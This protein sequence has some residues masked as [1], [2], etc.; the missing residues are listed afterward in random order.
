LSSRGNYEPAGPDGEF[1]DTAPVF[2]VGDFGAFVSLFAP[3]ASDLVVGASDFVAEV[4]SDEDPDDEADDDF[5][6]SARL[7]LR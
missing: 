3:V 4:D 6:V 2:G 7:S 1:E 5:E